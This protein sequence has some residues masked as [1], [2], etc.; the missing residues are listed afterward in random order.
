MTWNPN[1]LGVCRRSW[2]DTSA[3]LADVGLLLEYAALLSSG[4]S[5]NG[6]QG[7]CRGPAIDSYHSCCLQHVAKVALR[8]LGCFC[9]LGWPAVAA[10]VCKHHPSCHDPAFCMVCRPGTH[11]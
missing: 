6:K 1:K 2:S 9:E 8:R 7:C 11:C 4:P 10:Q 3:L 5:S